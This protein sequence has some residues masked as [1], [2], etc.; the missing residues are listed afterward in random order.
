MLN[1]VDALEPTTE[2]AARIAGELL[3]ATGTADAVDAIVAAEALLAIPAVILTSDHADLQRLVSSDV[4]GRDRRV[5]V[6]GVSQG[7]D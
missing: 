4:E 1:A 2:V 3:G 5:L 6:I 7:R